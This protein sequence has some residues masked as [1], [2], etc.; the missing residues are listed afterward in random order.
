MKKLIISLIV[1]LCTL[2]ANADSNTET[3]TING[4]VI[5]VTGNPLPGAVIETQ[6]GVTATADADG[7]FTMVVPKKTKW[8]RTSYPGIGIKLTKLKNRNEPTGYSLI[9]V[10]KTKEHFWFYTFGLGAA[11]SHGSFAYSDEP[12]YEYKSFTYPFFDATF[13]YLNNWGGYL[14]VNGFSEDGVAA[15][16]GFTK[17]LTTSW[18]QRASLYFYGGAGYDAIAYEDEYECCDTA[19]AVIVEA[20]LISRYRHFI[21]RIGYGHSFGVN[22][23]GTSCDRISFSI[24]FCF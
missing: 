4:A 10:K 21:S 6:D 15:I 14:S 11:F 20:G 17:R 22:H 5:D 16:G 9:E 19:S 7:S 1:A 13:G 24:G 23:S 8:L 2:G 12:D 18:N 3:R